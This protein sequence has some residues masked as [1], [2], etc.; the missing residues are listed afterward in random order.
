MGKAGTL[1]KRLGQRIRQLRHTQGWTQQE[2]AEKAG[3]DF[4]YLGGVERGERNVTIGNIEKIAAGLAVEAHQLFLFSAPDTPQPEEH[5]TEAKIR[6]LLQHSPPARKQLMWHL[7]KEVT[8]W[9][10]E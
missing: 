4:K 2:L 5:L 7:L 8:L 1:R 10:G 6:D 9:S 3:L